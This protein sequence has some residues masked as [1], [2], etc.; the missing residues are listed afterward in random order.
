MDITSVII[1]KPRTLRCNR[2]DLVLDTESIKFSTDLIDESPKSINF[3]NII[4]IPL[5]V[6]PLK[7]KP[8]LIFRPLRLKIE[9]RADF[10]SY[11]KH[12]TLWI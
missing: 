8:L 1:I 4:A 11:E 7:C 6:R 2:V 9:S 3:L 12:L 5:L 10:L